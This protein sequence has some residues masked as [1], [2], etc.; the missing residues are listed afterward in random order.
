MKIVWLADAVAEI[1][2][3]VA[4]LET[5]NKVAAAA[6]DVR[7][8]S[9]V[10]HLATF[11]EAGRIGRVPGTR[12]LVVVEYPYIVVYRILAAE[13]QILAVR[14]TSRQWPT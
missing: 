4:D 2:E 6:I 12:E 9:A 7:I 1:A 3:I 5:V 11:P 8:C 14:H 10:S 13:V